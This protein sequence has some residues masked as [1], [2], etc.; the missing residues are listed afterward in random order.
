MTAEYGSSSY[1]SS[2]DSQE[3]NFIGLYIPRGSFKTNL[4]SVIFAATSHYIYG[5]FF[6]YEAGA[7]LRYGYL[8]VG[9]MCFVIATALYLIRLDLTLKRLPIES[10]TWMYSVYKTLAVIFLTHWL[11]EGI[12]QQLANLTWELVFIGKEFLDMLHHETRNAVF[13]HLSSVITMKMTIYVTYVEGAVILL[14]VLM[15]PN[16][17]QD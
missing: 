12:W 5:I 6:N 1:Y 3:R 10:R 7:N 11:L 17:T 16:T 13:Q 2:D 15:N 14:I 4:L 8:N 9:S